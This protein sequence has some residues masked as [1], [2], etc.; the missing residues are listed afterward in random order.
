[1]MGQQILGLK[2]GQGAWLASSGKLPDIIQTHLANQEPTEAVKTWTQIRDV[3]RK[4]GMSEDD[5]N[6]QVPPT[7][8]MGAGL[9]NLGDRQFLVGQAQAVAANKKDGTPIPPQYQGDLANYNNVMRAQGELQTEHAKDLAESQGKF[10]D[11]IAKST[12]VEQITNGIQ[13][14]AEIDPTTGKQVSVLQAIMNDPLKKAAAVSLMKESDTK[15]AG[16]VGNFIGSGIEQALASRLTP[17]EQDVVAKLKQLSS[18]TYAT[19]FTS[20]GS[21]RTQQ[22]VS[23]IASS[24][25]QLGNMNQ[26]YGSYMD[27]FNNLH[28]L[29]QVGMANAYG[30][31]QRL[32]EVPDNLKPLV[33]SMYLPAQFDSKG[34][35][36]RAK[37]A[38]Y[39]GAGGDWATKASE[40]AAPSQPPQQQPP[41]SGNYPTPTARQV[42]LLKDNPDKAA[43]FDARFGPGASSKILGK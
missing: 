27:A 37:G 15:G 40:Q 24:L 39:T 7:L 41:Q 42:Q 19:A 35:Q 31:A 9:A 29:N 28:H 2:P 4:Q 38:L 8:I 6:T 16:P 34:N 14:A 18:S 13:G 11:Q 22:E 32:D 36:I 30:A 25:S 23:N 17:E 21:R 26:S 43:D 12:E 10:G 1:M 5:I 3:L 33:S 20:T